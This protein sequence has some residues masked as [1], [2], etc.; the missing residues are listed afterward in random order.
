MAHLI[1]SI[2]HTFYSIKLDMVH[3]LFWEQSLLGLDYKFFFIKSYKFVLHS[4]MGLDEVTMAYDNIT[5]RLAVDN[6]RNGIILS[7]F[8]IFDDHS[9]S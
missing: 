3:L 8:M 7:I 9:A 5:E 6:M 1:L 2:I 4:I